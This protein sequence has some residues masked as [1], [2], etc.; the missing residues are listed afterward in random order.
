MR[1]YCVSL[2]H[3]C[4]RYFPSQKTAF[5][6]ARELSLGEGAGVSVFVE[7]VEL[8]P[9]T[10]KNVLDILNNAGGRCISDEMTIASFVNG[11]R[12]S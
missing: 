5:A 12:V 10:L 2:N 7:Q 4:L 9:M 8:V 11:R 6:A 1:A 3:P